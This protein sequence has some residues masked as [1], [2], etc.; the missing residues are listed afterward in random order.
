MSLNRY[1]LNLSQFEI[2]LPDLIREIVK[3]KAGMLVGMVKLR[4]Y[5]YGVD[6]SGKEIT[7]TYAA[8]TIKRK[9]EKG[10]RASHVTLRDEGLFYK[11]FYIELEGDTIVLN[12]SDSKT[13]Y[14]IDKYG[15]AI[16]EFTV[17]EQ[18]LIFSI[19]E[20]GIEQ[21]LA[22]LTFNTGSATGIDVD[23]F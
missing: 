9:K 14:L 4:L 23:T 11:G 1:I 21:K 15:N 22:T 10:Q 12:S 17:Q 7:P 5:Q 13:S 6:G 20:T 2:K 18:E 8:S 3:S 19:I 16:L